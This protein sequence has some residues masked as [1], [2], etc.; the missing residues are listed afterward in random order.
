MAT[1]AKLNVLLTADASNF[2]KGIQSATKKAGEFGDRM[3]RVG[4]GMSAAITLPLA[5]VGAAAVKLASDAE[6]AGNKFDVVMGPAADRM[7]VRLEGLTT[8]IP[9][10]RAEME[11]MA[12]GI[13]DM[14]VPMGLARGEAANM[15]VDMVK[16]AGDLG[17][18]NNVGTTEV[19]EAMQSALAGSSEPM[20][21][22]GVDTRVTRLEALAL[23]EGIIKQGEKLDN[24]TTALA[25]MAAIQADSTDAMGDAARTVDSTA[26][27]FKFLVR[28]IQ[29][30]GITIGQILIPA[31]TPIVQKFSEWIARFQDLAPKMQTFIVKV[32]AAA[33]ALGPLLIVIGT[34]IK[35]AAVLAG[36]FNPVTL[37]VG[38]ATAALLLLD[39]DGKKKVL[40]ALKAMAAGLKAYLTP[41][42]R[43][44]AAVTNA[45]VEIVRLWW[46]GMKLLA[47]A[48]MWF[49]N[50]IIKPIIDLF[51]DLI[52]KVAEGWNLIAGLFGRARI[53]LTDETSE[54]TANVGG[55]WE[56]M[57]E[58]LKTLTSG[59]TG[60]ITG[61]FDNLG[62]DLETKVPEVVG[63]IIEPFDGLQVELPESLGTTIDNVDT[64]MDEW[65]ISLRDRA[66]A[67]VR[68]MGDEW[69]RIG[70]VV[71]GD[72]FDSNLKNALEK[73]WQFAQDVAA[74]L[75]NL[76]AALGGDLGDL[77]DVF[78]GMG[79]PGGGPPGPGSG[80]GT[81]L[82]GTGV[83]GPT[84]GGPGIASFQQPAGVGSVVLNQTIAIHGDVMDADQ[85]ALTVSAATAQGIE[86]V[87]GRNVRVQEGHTGSARI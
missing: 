82:P 62:S 45:V 42:A 63:E 74:V 79:G 55:L 12:G 48:A 86:R 72:I 5:A 68:G 43:F 2:T 32:A 20:R 25:V 85:L 1:L 36:A 60:F 51:G 16:L 57:T 80:T 56:D 33:A 39:K 76:L 7:R 28:D 19:L 14:L 87:M 71:F 15:S 35:I 81:G 75:R 10:T 4:K 21:R 77:G 53:E 29:Q 84:V 8:T 13:Q 11:K 83:G 38:A 30:M 59:A 50:N 22:F 61:A 58:R 27:S 49:W 47:P 78:S 70:D 52:S 17:S 9:L 37:A 67:G 41:L 40:G 54:T 66:R 44:V 18:F 73:W 64:K 26:N 24:T 3:A 31:V 6:E 23:T 46:E 34:T 65:N 69:D